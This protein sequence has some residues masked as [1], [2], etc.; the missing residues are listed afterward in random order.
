MVRIFC[1]QLSSKLWLE[2]VSDQT[3]ILQIKISRPRD[4]VFHRGR[5]LCNDKMLEQEA[6]GNTGDV[7]VTKHYKGY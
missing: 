1:Y 3:I 6:V 5:L 7:K 2:A 4:Y